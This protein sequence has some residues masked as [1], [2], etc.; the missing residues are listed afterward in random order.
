VS[1]DA[2]SHG[3]IGTPPSIL[4][5]NTQSFLSLFPGKNPPPS[6][7]PSIS[8][9][10][11]ESGP[12]PLRLL[13]EKIAR[14]TGDGCLSSQELLPPIS[15]RLFTTGDGQSFFYRF[16]LFS[17]LFGVAP[18]FDIHLVPQRRC[19]CFVSCRVFLSPFFSI[20]PFFA[21]QDSALNIAELFRRT[22]HSHHSGAPVLVGYLP[23]FLF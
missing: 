12:R 16:S 17:R 22:G 11:S 4:P 20:P 10:F 6:F 14:L 2:I 1:S 8:Y 23:S 3:R 19:N 13:L 9:V 21:L 5:F 15:G 18:I 7:L